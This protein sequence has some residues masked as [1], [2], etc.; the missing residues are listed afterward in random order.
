MIENPWLVA[1]LAITAL[2]IIGAALSHFWPQIQESL[3]ARETRPKA[4][5]PEVYQAQIVAAPSRPIATDNDRRID[6]F[7]K[8]LDVRDTITELTAFDPQKL[9]QNTE[10]LAAALTQ[11]KGT[12]IE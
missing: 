7:G 1:A 10:I 11:T 2:T 9:Q 8:T 3:K 12:K 5:A 4:F 6:A